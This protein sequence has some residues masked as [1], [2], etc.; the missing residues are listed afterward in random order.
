MTDCIKHP[1]TRLTRGDCVLCGREV[2]GDLERKLAEMTKKY[3]IADK[4]GKAVTG[5]A[6]YTEEQLATAQCEISQL[7]GFL[8]FFVK[9]AFKVAKTSYGPT[10]Q[11][12]RFWRETWPEEYDVATKAKTALKERGNE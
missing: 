7:R 10:D 3:E 9:D 1:G 12:M 8:E 4:A 2:I 5:G 6:L 11:W